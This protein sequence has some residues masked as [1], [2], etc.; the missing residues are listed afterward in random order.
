MP[1]G[2]SNTSAARTTVL[3]VEADLDARMRHEDA[4]SAAGYAVMTVTACPEPADVLTADL[5]LSDVPSFHWLQ[6]QNIGIMPPI[7]ALAPDARGGVT[8]C[9]CGA[10]AWVPADGDGG[11]LLDTVD[12]VLH[13]KRLTGNG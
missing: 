3:L 8:A 5:V 1:Q 7:V 11:Y 2:T 13:P 9:L 12:G 10:A 4:L 6:D